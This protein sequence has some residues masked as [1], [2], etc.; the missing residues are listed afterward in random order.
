M[1]DFTLKY[2]GIFTDWLVVLKVS[3]S[4]LAEI[5]IFHLPIYPPSRSISSLLTI[6]VHR[7]AIY[8]GAKEKSPLAQANLQ[9]SKSKSIN[10]EMIV[11]PLFQ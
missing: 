10:Q 7:E 8:R 5:V 11:I 6:C 1:C 4:Y 2:L 3:L 9:S